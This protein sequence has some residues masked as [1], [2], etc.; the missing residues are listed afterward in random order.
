M[1]HTVLISRD[2]GVSSFQLFLGG[3]K[4][5]FV[6]FNAT[7][8]LKNRKKNSMH[9]TCAHYFDIMTN[10]EIF[11]L[12][13]FLGVGGWLKSPMTPLN[14]LKFLF[15]LGCPQP[16]PN[17]SPVGMGPKKRFPCY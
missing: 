17:D 9:F 13:Y 8:L 11:L 16:F 1:L 15:S 6:F 7:A 2:A 5:F 4:F 12:A 10:K 14:I 3:P